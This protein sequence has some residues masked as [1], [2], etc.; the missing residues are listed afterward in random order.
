MEIQCPSSKRSILYCPGYSVLGILAERE[1]LFFS[2]SAWV[3]CSKAR[4]KRKILSFC[5]KKA[6]V[7]RKRASSHEHTL[8]F[9]RR[10]ADNGEDVSSL[11][12]DTRA[13][14]EDLHRQQ[15][16][17]AR[18][19]SKVQWAEEGEASTSYFFRLEKHNGERRLFSAVRTMCGVIVLSLVDISRVWVSLRI[20]I[21]CSI[22]RSFTSRFF[23]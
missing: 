16:R 2:L 13:E 6:S 4:L 9:L 15:S 17:G 12:A 20:I 3:G 14:L 11:I 10:R 19:R 21:Y 1:E 18:I 7:S 8:F 23:S 5:S 22:S